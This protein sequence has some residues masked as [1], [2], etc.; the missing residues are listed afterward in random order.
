MI[1]QILIS[2]Q[3]D[4]GGLVFGTLFGKNYICSEISPRKSW[5]GIAGSMLFSC[6][7]GFFMSFTKEY[8]FFL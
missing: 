1:V 2:F 6:L 5:E 4:N 7:T 8:G 3:S